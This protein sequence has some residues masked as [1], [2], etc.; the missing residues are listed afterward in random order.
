MNRTKPILVAAISIAMALTLSCSGDDG[1]NSSG[2]DGSSSSGA[3]VVTEDS[4]AYHC[5]FGNNACSMAPYTGSGTIKALL[6]EQGCDNESCMEI[7]DVGTVVNGI[8]NLQLPSSFSD[9]YLI[10]AGAPTNEESEDCQTTVNT[11]QFSPEDVKFISFPEFF[12][13]TDDEKIYKL[14]AGYVKFDAST[15]TSDMG[16]VLSIY[17]TK[18]LKITGEMKTECESGITS[19]QE[20]YN[21]DSETG[22]SKMY[23]HVE[24]KLN[25]AESFIINSSNPSVLKYDVK[26]LVID[27][28]NQ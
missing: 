7:I 18:A 19:K 20:T 14:F 5:G 27:A 28:N 23:H 15:L 3:E 25:T 9:K 13:F 21:F 22:W 6:R 11:V 8:V 4:Q 26:W 2:I 1:G 16:A 24:V 10:S 17:S 12:L